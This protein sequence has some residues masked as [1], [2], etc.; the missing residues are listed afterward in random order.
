MLDQAAFHF[1]W[2]D[3]VAS[4]LDHIVAAPFIPKIA[5]NIHVCH[6]ASAAPFAGIF[7]FG[8]CIVA[9]ITQ[10]K[11]RIEV[12]V[13]VATIHRHVTRLADG[14]HTSEWVN[15][16]DLMAGVGAAHAARA[17]GPQRSRITHDVVEFGLPEHLV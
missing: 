4:T 5:V 1:R 15:H 9:K 16:R 7:L 11:N 2:A 14:H 3:A 13:D 8:T 12:A 10:K 6:V 17:G